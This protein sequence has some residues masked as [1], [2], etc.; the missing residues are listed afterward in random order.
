M[1]LL[2]KKA[3][4]SGEK[5]TGIHIN[6]SYSFFNVTPNEVNIILEKLNSKDKKKR[7]LVECAKPV[8]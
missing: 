3:K 7:P 8:K 6:D 1:D 2:N 4:I 5:I